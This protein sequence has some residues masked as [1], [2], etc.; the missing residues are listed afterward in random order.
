MV[1]ENNVTF[2]ITLT[3]FISLQR[4]EVDRD[5]TT[6][7]REL[8]AEIVD[9]ANESYKAACQGDANAVQALLDAI[10]AADAAEPNA[11][12]VAALCRGWVLLGCRK[13][14]EQLK[15]SFDCLS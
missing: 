2:P 5:F 9:M 14:A 3:T 12:R 15:A 8:F 10:N 1:N 7:E 6:T 11:Q 4:A 13:G